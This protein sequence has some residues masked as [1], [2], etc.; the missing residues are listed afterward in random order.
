M[1]SCG[2]IFGLLCHYKN[3]PC[4]Q[5]ATLNPKMCITNSELLLLLMGVI[6]ITE[7]RAVPYTLQKGRIKV[8][9]LALTIFYTLK[10]LFVG[11]EGSEC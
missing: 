5:T 8:S 2:A 1:F 10:V 11:S 4:F 6:C 9:H 3:S 7:S